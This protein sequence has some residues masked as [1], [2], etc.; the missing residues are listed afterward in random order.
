MN[1]NNSVEKIVFNNQI[2]VQLKELNYI[3]KFIVNIF[4]LKP[5]HTRPRH[6]LIVVPATQRVRQTGI[7]M[8]AI[9][10]R[11]PLLRRILVAGN[12]WS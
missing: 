1:F 6:H 8:A 7:G 5:E 11:V 3:Y 4:Y 10:P 9:S 12:E 2:T